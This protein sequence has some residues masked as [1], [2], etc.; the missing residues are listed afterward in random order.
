M[1]TAALVAVAAAGHRARHD[2]PY[3]PV[4]ER[5][6]VRIPPGLETPPRL[7]IGFVAD[8]HLGSVIRPVDVD[9]ALGLLLPTEPDLLLFGGDYVSESPRH[10]N[11]AAAVLGNVASATRYGSLAVLG[12]H[13]YANGAARMSAA[14]EK[15]GIR[16][17]RNECARVG[18]T[19]GELW[20]AGMDDALL[21]SPEPERAF[22]SLPSGARALAL[23][24]EP[25]WAEQAAQHDA[26]LQLSGH[27]HGGQVLLPIGG[28]VA[29]PEGG[30][31]FVEGLNLALGMPVYT[32]RG[33]GVFRP[34]VRFRCSPEV[35]LLTLV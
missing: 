17:L 34:P 3:R 15:R 18:D 1:A 22:A 31:R 23:W 21:G 11:E 28:T 35:T 6:E 27:S 13:D 19:A 12:N 25:D 8:T 29:A 30:R 20:V 16:V 14:L 7:R 9:R 26:F 2:A 5:I 33:V 4:L 32:T 24:H 10:I